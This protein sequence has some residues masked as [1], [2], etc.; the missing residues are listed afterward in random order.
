M[1]TMNGKAGGNGTRGGTRGG[2]REAISFCRICAGGCGTRLTIGP[3]DRIL[4][5][6]GDKDN[7][8]TQGYACFKGLRAHEAHNHPA[9]LLHAMKKQ[10]DGSHAPIPAEQ[11]L[12]EVAAR[13][14]ALMAADGPEAVGVFC[15][16][17]SMPNATAYPMV[18]SFAAAIGSSQFY[19]T[20]TIDQSA[21]MISFGR[22]G[23]WA[24]GAWE[25]DEMDV[26]LLFGAN[27]LVSHAASG[28]LAYDPVRQLKEAKARGLK[29]AVVDPRETETG[30]FA[31]MMLRPLP[32]QDAAIC[33]GMIRIILAEGWHDAAFCADHVGQA[34][35]AALAAAVAPFEERAVEDRAGLEPGQLRAL[36]ELFARDS[37][38]GIAYAATGP[39]MTAWSNLAQHMIEVLNVVCGRFPRAGEPARR[40][41]A[42]GPAFPRV[43][44]VIAPSRP[45]EADG[46]SRIRGAKSLF[47]EKPSGTLADEILTPGE[48][49]LKALI[50][51]GG[52][53]ALSLPNQEKATKALASLD[54]L[55]TIDPWMSPTARLADYIFAPAMQYEQVGLSLDIPGFDFWPGSWA[56]YTPAAVSRPAGSDLVDDWYV[57][58]ALAKRLGAPV[59]YAGKGLLDMERAPGADEVLALKLTGSQVPFDAIRQHPHGHDFVGELGTVLAPPPGDLPKFGVMPPDVAAELAEFGARMD[60]S[61]RNRRDGRDYGFLMVTRRLRDVFN[62][63][64]TQLASVRKRTPSNPAW[65]NGEDMAVLGLREG[66]RV[67]L[68]SSAGE[69]ILLAARDDK[70]RRGCVQ[71]SHGWGNLPGETGGPEDGVCINLLIDDERHCEAINAMPHFS[72]VPVDVVPL[73]NG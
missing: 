61:Q 7:P 56:Q 44:Q 32:G 13:L 34:G 11:A 40:A 38:K 21:K 73:P 46:P 33:A 8:L 29:L 10:P 59:D 68:R 3:D 14:A 48:G 17:G 51:A 37:A 28:L 12:D 16:N 23:A 70:V 47:G 65:L 22:L 26:L 71:T 19:S 64:G 9:R 49:Q 53:P 25:V 18:R 6:R 36:T 24:G 58:W 1:A 55:V 20:L 42:Q 2:P 54:L 31:D 72:G 57:F 30:Y 67:Q 15:G 41:N 5:I 69:V 27:P 62:S 4:T 66:D 35:M 43:A 50:V 52:N 45:W 39:N 60:A 63:T